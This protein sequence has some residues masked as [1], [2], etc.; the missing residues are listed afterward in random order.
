MVNEPT[1]KTGTCSLCGG[2][3]EHYGNNPYPL[4]EVDE[5]CCDQCNYERVIPARLHKP[6]GYLGTWAEAQAQ[7]AALVKQHSEK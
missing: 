2:P 4:A 7:R 5:R 6:E 3:Y 1:S